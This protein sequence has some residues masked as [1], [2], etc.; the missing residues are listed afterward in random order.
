MVKVD[1]E[2]EQVL[3]GR[4]GFRGIPTL[5][6]FHGSREVA[7]QTGATQSD[8]IVRSAHSHGE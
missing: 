4:F 1:T 7:R 6:V 2:S 5:A 8:G 3:G